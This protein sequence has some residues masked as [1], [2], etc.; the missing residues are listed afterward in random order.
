MAG[1]VLVVVVIMA[2]SFTLFIKESSE[3]WEKWLILGISVVVGLG[4][5]FL[6][7]KL[8]KA[9]VFLIGAWLGSVL[10]LILYQAFLTHISSGATWVMIVCIAVCALACGLL[11]FV[12]EK[13]LVIIGTALTGSYLALRSLSFFVGGWP[14]ETQ[15]AKFIENDALEAIPH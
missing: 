3:D 1:F 13:H 11:A 15:I 2:I 12:L 4:V 14:D 8:E 5:G 10:G 9:G 6:C 7:S